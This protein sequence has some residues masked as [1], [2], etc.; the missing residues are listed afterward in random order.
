MDPQL[1]NP[2]ALLEKSSKPCRPHGP[3]LQISIA[4]LTGWR[5]LV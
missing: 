5:R 3:I 2:C 4:L 1:G